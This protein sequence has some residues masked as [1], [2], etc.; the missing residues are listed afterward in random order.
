[1]SYEIPN[2][3]ISAVAWNVK[4][5]LGDPNRASQIVDTITAQNPTV[6]F[7]SEAYNPHNPGVIDY[8]LEDLEARGYTALAVAQEKDGDRP[9][10]HGIVM[11]AKAEKSPQIQVIELAGRYALLAEMYDDATAEDYDVFGHHGND[12]NEAARLADIAELGRYFDLQDGEFRTPTM[13]LTDGNTLKRSGVLPNLL[14]AARPV[15]RMLPATPP[16]PNNPPH[17]IGRLGSLAQRTS[18]M[19]TGSAYGSYEAYGLSNA[20]PAM[21]PTIKQ[22]GI[23]LK[24]DHIWHSPQLEVLDHTVYPY[25]KIAIAGIEE[26]VS[27]HKEISA[28]LRLQ[29]QVTYL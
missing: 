16:D 29:P 23:P 27:D 17:G 11:I 2:P 14:Y 21:E 6:A 3:T 7:F 28:E 8:A 24:L 25:E 15:A 10:A 19:A 13:V 20:D 9:D 22:R 4:D 5:G 12:I 18:A 26:F 1:M